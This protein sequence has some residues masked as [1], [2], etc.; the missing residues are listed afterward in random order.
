[1]DEYAYRIL[2][3]EQ[4][5]GWIYAINLGATT[6]WERWNSLLEDGTV[7]GTG[8]NSFNHYAYGSVC[9]AIYSRIAG[10]MNLSPGWKK[11][12]IKPHLNYRMKNIELVY[13]SI[14]GK[15]EISW[16][17]FDNKFEMNVTIPNGC[18]AEIILPNNEAHSVKGGKYSYEC[19]LSNNIYSPFSIDTPIIDLIK[20]DEAN[21]ILK[22]FLPQIYQTINEKNEGFEVNSISSANLLPNFVYPPETIKKVNE[23]LSKIKP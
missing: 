6:I 4:F 7:S 16:K 15:Y 13:N 23:E 17:W 20:N 14:S 18:E 5:P 19:Q 11:V 9:E 21:K 22:E 1:M 3:N 10:L 2:Y 12:I 8:M